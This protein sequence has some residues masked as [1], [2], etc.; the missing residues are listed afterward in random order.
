MS[1]ATLIAHLQIK[2]LLRDIGDPSIWE[3]TPQMVEKVAEGKFY[4]NKRYPENK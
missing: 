1:N 2:E 3:P 4:K